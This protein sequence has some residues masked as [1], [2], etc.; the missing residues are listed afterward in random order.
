VEEQSALEANPEKM[1]PVETV[2]V[3]DDEDNWCFVIKRILQKAGVGNQII[4]AVNGQDALNKLQGIAATGEKLPEL[5]FLD[6]K[7]P[8]MD[9]F[10]FLEAA[11]KAGE[12]NLSQ[13]R[14]FIMT[15][16]FL[17]KDKERANGY[18]IAGFISKP[19][20]QEIL[21]DILS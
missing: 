17:P 8:V 14:I 15:S 5:I 13:T 4:T 10:G 12:L 20:T 6:L 21:A 3:V 9:G 7:M 2:L 19:L 16:S 11:T 18:P 1:P